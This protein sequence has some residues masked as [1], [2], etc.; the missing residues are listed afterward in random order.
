MRLNSKIIPLGIVLSILPFLMMYN[1]HEYNSLNIST[2]KGEL[3]DMKGIYLE[4][5]ENGTKNYNKKYTLSEKGLSS[6]GNLDKRTIY[7]NVS[8][9]RIYY[10]N[11]DNVEYVGLSI[12]GDFYSEDNII[13]NNIKLFKPKKDKD[14]KNISDL[15]SENTI[16]IYDLDLSKYDI[17]EIPF[18]RKIINN[19][20]ENNSISN[21]TLEYVVRKDNYIYA[22]ISYVQGNG[23][24]VLET[25]KINSKDNTIVKEKELVNN[26]YLI[27]SNVLKY[28]NNALIIASNEKKL[29]LVEYNFDSQKYT[30]K[31]INLEDDFEISTSYL[32]NNILSLIS[33]NIKNNK[34]SIV[35]YDIDLNNGKVINK[36]YLEKNIDLNKYISLSSKIYNSDYDKIAYIYM[37]SDE[38][39][40]FK[41]LDKNTKELK[42]QINIKNLVKENMLTEFE[43]KGEELYE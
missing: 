12:N 43:L 38:S 29:I 36:E 27:I 19:N 37:N 7:P 1:T 20:N 3:S 35:L 41:I 4:A 31:Y 11:S 25:L 5:K 17:V 22:F 2:I 10:S 24:T 26:D 6:S 32:D 16:S 42:L 21:L 39:R 18:K 13:E 33:S 28:N 14:L 15:S 9:K 23:K 34:Y 40:T 8:L 30:K